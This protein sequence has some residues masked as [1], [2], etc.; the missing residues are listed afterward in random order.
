MPR[1]IKKA[2]IKFLSLVPKGANRL[3]TIFKSDGHFE[4]RMLTKSMNELGELTAIVYAP[5]FR[6]SQG[7]IASAD[8]I[9][10]MLY[11]AAKEGVAIDMRHDGQALTKDQVFVAEQFLVQKGDPR[12]DGITDYD[13]K[14]VDPTGAWG[15]VI[16]IDDPGLRKLYR[17]GGWEGVSMGG[18]AEVE[19]EKEDTTELANRIVE[20]LAKK[21]SPE[22]PVALSK[23]DRESIAKIAAEAALAAVQATKES[24]STSPAPAP[25]PAGA[26]VFKGD[27]TNA[28][29][30]KAYRDA[31]RKHALEQRLAKATTPEQVDAVLKELESGDESSELA[32]ARAEAARAQERLR[33]M[34]GASRQPSA[35]PGQ[36]GTGVTYFDGLSKEAQEEAELGMRMA[37]WANAQR[38]QLMAAHGVAF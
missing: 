28:E 5:E 1:R 23:E 25:T 4:L 26:P 20:R 30:L 19:Q 24:T 34:E 8:V 17:E 29:D 36:G 11:A 16:K 37:K 6:D 21:L 15:V 9:K 33:K 18:V 22:E 14:P 32:K 31:L 13:G 7:D 10:D 35:D 12:F 3:P 27:P 2:R 38:P